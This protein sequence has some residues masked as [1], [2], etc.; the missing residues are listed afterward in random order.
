[1]I[2]VKKFKFLISLLGLL[3]VPLLY[4]AEAAESDFTVYMTEDTPFVYERIIYNVFNSQNIDPVIKRFN[5]VEE[6]VQADKNTVLFD[7]KNTALT[8]YF[9]SL[10]VDIEGYD[11]YCNKENTEIASILKKGLEEIQTNG[12][13]NRIIKGQSAT[14]PGDKVVFVLGSYS[15]EMKWESDFA[16]AVHKSFDNYNSNVSIFLYEMGFRR[17]NNEA[18]QFK[19]AEDYIRASFVNEYPDV[20]I[21]ADN[22]AL[23]FINRY[24]DKYFPD[25]PVV[26]C[27]VN[28]F[29]ESLISE[30]S[31][32]S[33]GIEESTA[34]FKTIDVALKINPDYNKVYFICD[35]TPTA[36]P[37]KD[38]SIEGV[39]ER[40]GDKFEVLYNKDEPLSETINEINALDS[41]TMVILLTYYIDSNGRFYTEDEL[42][43]IFDEQLKRPVYLKMSSFTPG[44]TTVGGVMSNSASFG[45]GAAE[46]AQRILDGEK[47]SNIPIINAAESTEIFDTA[48]FNR[49][50]LNRF[51]IND[52]LLPQNSTI[53]NEPVSAFKNNPKLLITLIAIIIG[54]VIIA[55]VSIIFSYVLGKRN[56]ALLEAQE[57]LVEKDKLIEFQKKMNENQEFVGS[58]LDLAPYPFSMNVEGKVISYNQA[59]INTFGAFNEDSS[60]ADAYEDEEMLK[61]IDTLVS[62]GSEVISHPV[63]LKTKEGKKRF[64]VSAT[65]AKY[66]RTDT[67]IHWAIDVEELELRSDKIRTAHKLLRDLII[68]LPVP[69]VIINPENH[70]LVIANNAVSELEEKYNIA[71]TKGE[72][73]EK[74]ITEYLAAKDEQ[75][76]VAVETFN[77][78]FVISFI[79]KNNEKFSMNLLA[80]EAM[81]ENSPAIILSGIDIS[82]QLKQEHL[83]K[84]AAEREKTENETKSMFVANMSHEMRTPL[85]AIIGM[86]TIALASD[87]M[88]KIM[89]CIHK[90]NDA[91]QHLLGEINDVLDMSKLESGKMDLFNE[92]FEF[93]K[94]INKVTDMLTFKANE[95]NLTLKSNLDPSIPV[96][97][98]GD[99]QK[100]AQVI[101]NIMNNAVKFTPDGGD[102]T[103]TAELLDENVPITQ[104]NEK[105]ENET[106]SGYEI[107]ISIKDTGIGIT[108]EQLDKLFKPFTQAD[109]STA[110]NFGG[111]GLGLTISKSIVEL[112]NG[113]IWVVSEY[114]KGSD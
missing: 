55:V 29:N 114:G 30:I 102:I 57:N 105:G 15:S 9:T 14:L 74:I 22:N 101:T 68:A 93:V 27:G 73:Y 51:D 7:V 96:V 112:M 48:T 88:D 32:C 65:T 90:I 111:T 6:S 69:L 79:L 12:V 82:A 71:L 50:A 35:N 60:L 83:L 52:K 63:I 95:K 59:F 103:L 113:R 104:K 10:N 39:A 80:G 78:H 49:S 4:T 67:A 42:C 33:T 21:T 66:N 64:L 34:P 8:T 70:A 110:R 62:E 92:E 58:I 106:V 85:N 3:I 20:I 16:N 98:V 43:D 13:Y 28:F 17:I 5:I 86:S 94:C 53:L 44:H 89:N 37:I 41:N 19:A 77:V 87:D 97:L 47:V 31:D 18:A 61:K 75:G 40:Y 23:T 76:T 99:G 100:L 11:F 56:R 25:V 45:K 72:R 2:I 81:F 26:F 108:K 84:I 109:S 1:M 24:H 38:S 91:S 107:K 46:I 36:K 54:A